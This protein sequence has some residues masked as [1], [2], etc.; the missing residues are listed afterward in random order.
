[1]RLTSLFGLVALVSYTAGSQLPLSPPIIMT[2]TFVNPAGP[3]L[4][5]LLTLQQSSSIFYDYL[6]D[7]PDVVNRLTDSSGNVQST[8]FVPRNKAVVQLARKP[9][10]GPVEDKIEILTGR[11]HDE[12]ARSHIAR[13]IGAHIV[14]SHP[15]E[16]VGSYATMLDGKTVKLECQGEERT[17]EHCTVDGVKIAQK[18]DAS[19]GVLYV[20]DGTITP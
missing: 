14:P 2:D 4:A 9:H 1:M 12:R 18:I 13:W 16:L 3:T 15:I 10:Q 17:W 20:I 5:D 7:L 8:V 11:E 6:R 19:N